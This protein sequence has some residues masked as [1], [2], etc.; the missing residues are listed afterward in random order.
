[1]DEEEILS[2]L[3]RGRTVYY[4]N[5]KYKVIKED[6]ELK[7]FGVQHYQKMTLNPEDY[8]ECRLGR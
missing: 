8:S 4:C 1:M 2:A 7:I 6:G 3:D 5:S